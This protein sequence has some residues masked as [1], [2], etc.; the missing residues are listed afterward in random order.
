[1]P[2]P[3][4]SGWSKNEGQM[5]ERTL[6]C[7]MKCIMKPTVFLLLIRKLAAAIPVHVHFR[8]KRYLIV[9]IEKAE[10]IYS[11]VLKAETYNE[12]YDVFIFKHA[13]ICEAVH[14]ETCRRISENNSFT[15]EKSCYFSLVLC[16]PQH[17]Q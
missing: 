15:G 10:C 7:Q 5:L 3:G 14:L 9:I 2:G 6:H 8:E 12:A 4:P 13:L 11:G 17:T 1:M 16:I